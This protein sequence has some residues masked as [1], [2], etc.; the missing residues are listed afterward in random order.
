MTE[1]THPS[2]DDP[3][4]PERVRA[5]DAATLR[6]IV[7]A[8]LPQIVRTGRGAGLDPHQAEDLA[9]ETF[10]TFFETASRFEGR[11][12]VRTWVFG[13]FYRKLA[14][15]RRAF[16][17]DRQFDGIDG[18]FEGRFAPDGRW[19]RPPAPADELLRR[20]E[21][22]RHID[23]CLSQTPEK[24]RLAFHLR[25]VEGLPSDEICKILEVS[26]TNLGVMLFRARNRLRECLETKGIRR[27]ADADV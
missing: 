22:R 12:H 8:Y 18:V 10:V 26:R 1:P 15:T 19:S 16:A 25:E 6:A 3:R 27:S 7:H 13:I 11:S 2:L 9:Q 4:L 20:G 21:A 17:K 14:E 5:R 24:Q 23:D